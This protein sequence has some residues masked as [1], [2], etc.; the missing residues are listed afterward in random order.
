MPRI[1]RKGVLGDAKLSA[2]RKVT[3]PGSRRIR[4]GCPGERKEEVKAARIRKG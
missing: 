1:Q 2:D 4:Q 3:V